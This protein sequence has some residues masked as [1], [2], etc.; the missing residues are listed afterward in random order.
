[1]W[2]AAGNDADR[3]VISAHSVALDVAEVDP[4][5]LRE[6]EK[7]RLVFLPTVHSGDDPLR[8]YFVY[9][10]KGKNDEWEEIRGESLRRLKKGEGYAL[11]LRSAEVSTL[12]SGLLSLKGLY[13]KH[14]VPFG[15]QTYVRRDTLPQIV[16]TIVDYPNSELADAL[17]ELD[18]DDILSLGRTVDISKLDALLSEWGENRDNPDE[19]FWQ[20]LLTRNAWVFSQLTGSP[21]VLL[22]ERAY[23][24]GKG[25][26]NKGGGQVDYLLRNELTDNVSFV[27]IKTPMTELVAGSYRSSGSFALGAEV[28]GGVVQVLGYKESFDNEYTS[29]LANSEAVFRSHNARCYLLAG[30]IGAMPDEAMRAFELFR[31]AL[32]GVQILAFDEVEKRLRGIKDALQ[33]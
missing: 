27:E 4:I 17:S 20:S 21:V 3:N 25:I 29:L 19:H 30:S 2:V 15:E 28:S 1:M 8:G 11:E 33:P 16:R 18:E 13:E 6:T 10:C 5:V 31:N 24:G 12:M 9:Q 14:G 22:G 32:A 23:V 26:D 7:V